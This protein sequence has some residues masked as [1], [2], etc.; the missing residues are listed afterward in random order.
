MEIKF[1]TDGWHETNKVYKLA[2]SV[3]SI[4]DHEGVDC[5]YE[6]GAFDDEHHEN[7]CVV[8]TFTNVSWRETN[9]LDTLVELIKEFTG[10]YEDEENDDA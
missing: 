9:K 5:S 2:R 7:D 10:V 1:K 6:V 3:F 4:Q 8:I